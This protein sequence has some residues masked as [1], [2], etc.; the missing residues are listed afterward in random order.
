MTELLRSTLLAGTGG[1]AGTCCRYLI[2]RL[3]AAH[4]RDWVFI[5][6]F[7]GTFLVN[8]LVCFLIGLFYGL[9][10]RAHLLS[11][12]QSLLLITGFCGGFTTYS[13]FADDIWRLADQGQW[14]TLSLYISATFI[15]GILMLILGR[16]IVN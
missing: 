14:A 7:S 1:F 5:P 10:E 15:I 3:F 6:P 16:G 11:S 9:F 13:T 8:V 4:A 12:S 2:G